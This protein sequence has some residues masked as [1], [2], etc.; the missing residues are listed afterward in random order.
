MRCC[1]GASRVCSRRLLL[2]SITFVHA[3]ILPTPHRRH[4]L[5]L[6][7]NVS[8]I[9]WDYESEDCAGCE[10][11]RVAGCSQGARARVCACV[12]NHS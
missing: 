2:A 10:F 7:A 3:P 5:S 12:A 8:S 11:E 4:S 9:R 6:Y 1:W